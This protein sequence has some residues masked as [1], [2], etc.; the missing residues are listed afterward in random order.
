M[1]PFKKADPDNLH[2]TYEDATSEQWVLRAELD[3]LLAEYDA[4]IAALEELGKQNAQHINHFDIEK[5]GIHQQITAVRAETI[6]MN[7][8]MDRL[9]DKL[10]VIFS[11]KGKK[12]DLL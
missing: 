2:Q 12:K 3:E 10:D 4:Q 6:A 9:N 7:A 11:I 1:W 8:K 5:V